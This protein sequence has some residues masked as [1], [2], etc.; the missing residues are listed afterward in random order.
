MD[1]ST[2]VI[3]LQC[4]WSLSSTCPFPATPKANPPTP[5]LTPH[6]A[7]PDSRLYHVLLCP[8]SEEFFGSPLTF[9]MNNGAWVVLMFT[10]IITIIFILSYRSHHALSTCIILCTWPGHTHTCTHTHI[11]CHYVLTASGSGRYPHGLAEHT[12]TQRTS[13]PDNQSGRSWS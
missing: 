4:L 7:P 5:Q 13:V 3:S 2:V 11:W 12:E 6:G 1:G 8:L 9:P 10:C